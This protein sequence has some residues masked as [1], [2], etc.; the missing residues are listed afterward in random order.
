MPDP[1]PIAI[2]ESRAPLVRV[3]VIGRQDV[4]GYRG[5][6]EGLADV[7]RRAPGRYVM[8]LDM[9]QFNP[10]SVDARMRREGAEV[11]RRDAELWRRSIVGEA[12]VVHNSLTKNIL[13]GI[14]WLLGEDRWPIQHFVDI[15]EAEA[16]LAELKAAD[17]LRTR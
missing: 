7:F 13:T 12:R 14:D 2:D 5:M 15:D 9:R 6:L 3:T 4:R 8:V 10:F 11:W 17:D 16:W 1:Q